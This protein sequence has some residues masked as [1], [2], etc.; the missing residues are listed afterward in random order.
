[1]YLGVL[2]RIPS[3]EYFVHEYASSGT[4][5][6]LDILD[7]HRMSHALQGYYGYNAVGRRY[8]VLSVGLLQLMSSRMGKLARGL[9]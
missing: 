1:M 6:F 5:L 9:D 2:K 3:E 7:M 4:I 8:T